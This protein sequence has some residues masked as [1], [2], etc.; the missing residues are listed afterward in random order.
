MA[1][2]PVFHASVQV[3]D[4][5][6][7][8]ASASVRVSETDAK[9][10]I[11]AADQAARDAT[12]VGLLL[13][14]LIDMQEAAGSQHY[15]YWG[16]QAQYI[17]DAFAF[18]AADADVYNSNRLKVTGTTLNNGIPAEDSFYIPARNDALDM[19]SNGVN[20]DLNGTEAANLITQVLDTALSKYG[21]AF[22][23]VIEI[24]VND[25]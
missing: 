15:K 18:P 20:I 12:K 22:S 11:A 3:G 25:V 4:S 1:I 24:T 2:V 7:H 21:T 6:K 23:S 17:N 13:D 10:Y 19:E 9:A 16:L 8:Y 14:G 5:A